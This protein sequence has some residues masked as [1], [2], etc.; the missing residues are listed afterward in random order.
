MSLLGGAS[1]SGQEKGFI[2]GRF[3]SSWSLK[4]F[5]TWFFRLDCL[6]K[7]PSQKLHLKNPALTPEEKLTEDLLSEDFAAVA[8]WEDEDFG[9]LGDWVSSPSALLSLSLTK[10]FFFLSG[11]GD[12]HSFSL[13]LEEENSLCL[14]S[15]LV[16]F[17]FF[18]TMGSSWNFLGHLSSSSDS[19]V[20]DVATTVGADFFAE[21]SDSS[22]FSFLAASLISL[23]CLAVVSLGGAMSFLS[24]CLVSI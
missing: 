5:T 17:L 19:D 20:S 16:A 14:F 7:T 21:E 10:T 23:S 2:G 18:F 11:A 15:F 4:W 3:L 12:S 24:P 6:S 1:H 13:S 22:P 8:A 9:V